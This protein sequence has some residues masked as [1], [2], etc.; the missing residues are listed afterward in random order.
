ML[1]KLL[2]GGAGWLALSVLLPYQSAAQ[3]VANSDSLAIATAVAVATQQ[4]T[5]AVRPESVLFNGPEYVNYNQPNTIGHQFFGS[6]DPQQGTITYRGADF[7]AVLLSYDLARDQVVMTYPNQLATIILVPEEVTVFSLGSHQFV[8]VSADSATRAA[9]PTGFY[10]LLLPGP[11]SLLARRTKKTEQTT[12]QQNL[13]LEFRQTDKLI[14][15]TPS[16]AAEVASLKDLLALLPK[17]RPEL[18]RYAR[19]EQLRFS[20][21]QREA[22][23]LS[24]LRHYY[25]LPQ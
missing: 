13:R 4:Y 18:Q 15:R 5:K 17:H 11:V 8:R 19:Q 9:L 22:S 12:V 7:Q 1:R 24:L 25:T 10:E 2:Y 21:A 23:A 3:S 6:P 16:A 20:T 14:V